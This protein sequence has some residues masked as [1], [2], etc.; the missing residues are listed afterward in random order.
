MI[1]DK[2]VIDLS[3]YNDLSPEQW[4]M[5]ATV[6]DGVIIRLSYG[7]TTDSLAQKHI[8]QCNR[9]GIPYSGYHWVDPTK[10]MILQV[11]K[12]LESVEKF[13]PKSMYFDY[14]QYW[15]DWDAYI[16]QDLVE[17]NRTKYTPQQLNTYYSIFNT[18][19]RQAITSI[20]VGNYSA[21]WFIYDYCPDMKD[22]I[23]INYW[24]ARYLRYYD[25]DFWGGEI[26]KF[27]FDI[28][29][30]RELA[31]S[32]VINGGIGRQFETY[33]E[34]K[35]FSEW[36]GWHLDWNI[37]SKNGFNRM[38]GGEMGKIFDMQFVSQLG[39][40]AGMHNN[41]C[42]EACCSMVLLESKDIFVQP[43]EW[44]K[45][46]GWGAPS[47]DVGTTAYQLQRA[48][49]LFDVRTSIGTSLTLTNIYNLID[50]GLPF[51]PLVDYGVL[52]AAKLTY[53]TGSFLHWIVVVGYDTNNIFALDPYRPESAG[54]KMTIPN[55]VFLNS[56]RQSYLACM[57]SIEGGTI[58]MAY[59][60]TITA[61][62]LNVRATPNGTLVGGLAMNDRVTI[63]RDTITSMGWGNV[64]ASNNAKNPLGWVFMAYV[65]MDAVVVPPPVTPPPVT[66]P[67]DDAMALEKKIRI[68][69]CRFRRDEAIA[70]INKIFNDRIEAL[71]G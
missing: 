71:G 36:K 41:D 58:P 44:Y 3:Y 29:Y 47:T 10:D 7:L 59:N 45:M 40:G 54:G 8:D 27:P 13:K 18:K 48:L 49:N 2:L 60:G 21:D 20:P 46:D 61:T 35:G 43:D 55:Q 62:S 63:N 42:G 1:D 68:D 22:W 11:K 57:D 51:I 32:V 17:A 25:A 26:S 31:N 24:E 33:I 39:V 69:E 9:L 67:V 19:V 66:P 34:I 50:R 70:A 56:Y 4:D 14:E 30:M 52:S 64:I 16:R 65:K 15:R 38:F 28:S 12:A 5:L 53:Y 37:F 23:K 6:V